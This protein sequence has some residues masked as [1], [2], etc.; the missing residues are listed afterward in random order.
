MNWRNLHRNKPHDEMNNKTKI[1][2][3]IWATLIGAASTIIGILKFLSIVN[4]PSTDALIH[5]ITGA[6]FIGG[7][8]IQKG[9]YVMITNLLLGV[10]YI[11]FG[12]IASLNWP[13]I[14]AGIISV[15]I[16]LLFR[17]SKAI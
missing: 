13:H 17:T 5:I 10:F 7:A 11:F 12:I 15:L 1:T 14:I 4:I 6:T 16:S 3:Q 2:Q 9:K 8:W